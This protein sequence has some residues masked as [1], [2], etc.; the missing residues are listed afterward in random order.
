VLFDVGGVLLTNG[1]D[2]AARRACAAAAG[3]GWEEFEARHQDAVAAFETG[4]MGIEAYLRQTVFSRPRSFGVDEFIRHMEA[5]SRPLPA[6]LAVLEELAAR[7]DAPL[8]GVLNNESRHLNDYRLD[9]FGLRD[10]FTAFFSSCYVGV[11]KPDERIYRMAI[12]VLGVPAAACLFVDDRDEN[13]QPA[14]ALG[15]AT[16]RFVDA[17]TLRERLLAE[18]LL[19]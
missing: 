5:Q 2:T 11:R 1:W 16:H 18:G 9:T 17:G 7:P 3:I 8:L 12:N 19:D 13:L 10:R 6:S 15:M 4:A 14:A